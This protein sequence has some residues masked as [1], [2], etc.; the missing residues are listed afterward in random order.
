MLS[1][2]QTAVSFIRSW[3]LL[4]ISV[5]INISIIS[6][7]L[8][9]LTQ[10]PISFFE[11]R[12]IGDILQRIDDHRRVENFLTSTALST[13]FSIFSII[14]FGV[15]LIIY[16][17]QIFL[18]FIF[19]SLLYIAWVMIFLRKRR[20]IDYKQFSRFSENQSK[21][22]EMIKGMHEIKLTNS[23]Q[24]KRWEWE[25]IQAKLFRS[26]IEGLI[27]EQYQNSGSFFIND[28]KNIVI[29]FISA[30]SVIDGNMTLGMMLAVQ[31]IVGQLNS[32]LNQLIGFI[33]SFQD[34][35]ISLERLGE[36][37]NE[38]NEE[39]RN[40]VT[41]YLAA[42]PSYIRIQNLSFNYRGKL[43]KKILDSINLEIPCGTTTAIVG[44]SGAGKTTLIKLLLKFYQASEGRILIDNSALSTL[45]SRDWRRKC[46]VVMQDG[47]FFSDSILKNITIG[48]ENIDFEKL[49]YALEVA[50][51]DSV[52]KSL[53]LGLNT[54]IGEDGSLFS[55][56]EKQRILI[57]RTIYRDPKFLF[58]DEATSALDAE[59]EKQIVQNL[60]SFFKGKTVFI[61]AHRLSTVK[62]ADQIV[63]MD[64]GKVIEIGSHIDLVQR[65]GKYYKLIKNQLELN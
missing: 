16:N 13:L 17:I 51:L 11:S 57:A 4:H 15:V 43:S 56:G 38:E 22:V 60:K 36:I 20:K 29:T 59:N 31:Y 44:R 54:R 32:P 41:S 42:S 3:L 39:N 52:I 64:Q 34:A 27:V 14:V 55:G 35:Q 10:L 21:L 18:V 23:E 63:T 2:S 6:D 7:F 48:A 26:R 8:K 28:I 25:G 62:H 5:R 12:L 19:G 30:L 46:G 24:Q 9:K 61:V 37:H 58:F 1:G 49:N 65:K 33:Q 45:S 40:Q 47:Y 53:P 50:N